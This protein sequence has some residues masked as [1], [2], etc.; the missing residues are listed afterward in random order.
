MGVRGP[1]SLWLNPETTVIR[2]PVV[3]AEGLLEEARSRDR[4]LVKERITALLAEVRLLKAE[5][6]AMVP[7]KT[8]AKRRAA[9]A[10]KRAKGKR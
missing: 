4:S 3:L 9:A 1:R 8:Q 2:V 7:S 6:A 5:L 10:R